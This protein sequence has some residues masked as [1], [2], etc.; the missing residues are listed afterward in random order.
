MDVGT[1]TSRGEGADVP[2]KGV[3]PVALL[4]GAGP[5]GRA[6]LAFRNTNVGLCAMTRC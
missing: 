1:D 4:Q 2:G 3:L 5:A 6:Q